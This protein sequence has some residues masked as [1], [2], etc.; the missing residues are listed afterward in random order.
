MKDDLVKRSIELCLAVYRVTDEFPRSEVLRHRSRGLAIDIV[1]FLVYKT[2]NPTTDVSNGGFFNAKN[3]RHKLKL[4]FA[5]FNIA[6]KQTWVDSRNF[7]TL[8]GVYISLY[9]DFSENNLQTTQT[10]PRPEK[11]RVT[12][13]TRRI[14]EGRDNF[15]DRQEKIITVIGKSIEGATM[16]SLAVVLGISKKTVERDLKPL[17]TAGAVYK[18]GQTRG[19]KF[20]K[21]S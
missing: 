21:G 8:K 5:Y 10:I 20:L 15:S 9:K 11:S 4:L 1:E 16:E 13:I 17:L 7:Q 19:A 14:K 18:Q 6:E 2:L 12:K 3:F